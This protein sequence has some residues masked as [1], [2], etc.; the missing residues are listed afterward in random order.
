MTSAGPQ[1]PSTPG[2]AAG[3]LL[4]I[5]EQHFAARGV[6]RSSASE[7]AN[8]ARM[9]R[10]TFYRRVPNKQALVALVGLRQVDRLLAE[11]SAAVTTE[12]T[13]A[14]VVVEGFISAVERVKCRE[15]LWLLVTGSLDDGG[16]WS[17]SSWLA[18][19]E[20]RFHE[21]VAPLFVVAQHEGLIRPE[22]DIEAVVAVVVPLLRSCS[23]DVSTTSDRG[24]ALRRLL[25]CTLVP[26]IVPDGAVTQ[27]LSPT[28]VQAFRR[29]LRTDSLAL[30]GVQ[31]EPKTTT[32]VGLTGGV[33]VG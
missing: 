32:V 12:V 27:R 2:D 33:C 16:E 30:P 11:L 5:A 19:A 4:D 23:A 26:M 29:A 15:P 10:A 18:Q 1:T 17:P 6:A 14:E 25:R 20:D 7:I 13:L 21:L 22:I 24:R 28:A 3:P 9:S 31:A 8:A